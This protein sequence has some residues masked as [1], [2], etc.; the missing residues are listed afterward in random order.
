MG[1]LAFIVCVTVAP[2]AGAWIETPVVCAKIARLK[3]HP[4]RVRGLKQEI[5]DEY[6][7]EGVVAPH[8]GAWIETT[9]SPTPGALLLVAPHAGA[10]IETPLNAAVPS[11]A[12][13]RTPRGCV[14]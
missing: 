1:I 8:A 4:T 10:W 13:S 5:G 11:W 14:D 9:S 3:S 2:H 12:P 6:P 7:G